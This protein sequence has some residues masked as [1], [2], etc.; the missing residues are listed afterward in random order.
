MLVIFQKNGK[1]GNVASATK[2]EDTENLHRKNV[3]MGRDLQ[4]L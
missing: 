2:G 3:N 1:A 4:G